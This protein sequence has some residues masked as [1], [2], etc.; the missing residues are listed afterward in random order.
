M[1]IFL[2]DLDQKKCAQYHNDKHVNKMLTESTQILSTCLQYYGFEAP[3]RKTHVNH[4]CCKWVRQSL[5]N[6]QWLWKLTDELGKEYTYRYGKQHKTQDILTWL[7]LNKPKIKKGELT[8]FVQ[9]M[10]DYC[11]R[12][13]PVMAYR[14]YYCEEKQRMLTWKKRNVPTWVKEMTNGI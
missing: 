2:L 14:A 1:N 3:Y 4:P 12:S 5:L 8:E 9:A 10:P 13:D 6:Y 11:K 7:F